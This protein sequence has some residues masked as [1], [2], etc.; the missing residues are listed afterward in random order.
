[1]AGK[2]KQKA[3]AAPAEDAGIDPTTGKVNVDE[4]ELPGWLKSKLKEIGAEDMTPQELSGWLQTV[5]AQRKAGVSSS[6]AQ[7]GV[8]QRKGGKKARTTL[9]SAARVYRYACGG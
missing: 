2:K 9:F 3:T 1:M 8:R 5:G 7:G 6:E 4:L